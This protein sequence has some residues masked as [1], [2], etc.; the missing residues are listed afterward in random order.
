MLKKRNYFVFSIY[1][2]NKHGVSG[3]WFTKTN[4]KDFMSGTLRTITQI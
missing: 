2:V 4:V 1:Q 3:R